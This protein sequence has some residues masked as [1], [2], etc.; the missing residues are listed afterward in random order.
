MPALF[1]SGQIRDQ[2]LD[3]D[4]LSKTTSHAIN[5]VASVDLTSATTTTIFTAPSDKTALIIGVIL[6]VTAAN[7]VT[8]P[9]QVSVGLNPSTTNVFAVET[10]INLDAVNNSYVYWAN[11]NKA[12]T[13]ANGGILDL[14]V[15]VA[16]TAT[17]LVATARVVGIIL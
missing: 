13:V 5:S 7:T 8:V 2:E 14:D 3:E 9:P 4:R 15:A 11:L 6:E 17:S 1:R 12:V 10:L 16:S